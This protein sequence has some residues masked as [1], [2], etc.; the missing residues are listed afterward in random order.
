MAEPLPPLVLTAYRGEGGARGVEARLRQGQQA[1]PQQRVRA[2]RRVRAHA[3]DKSLLGARDAH[4]RRLARGKALK[5]GQLV[6][7][8]VQQ[9]AVLLRLRAVQHTRQ[10]VLPP[11]QHVRGS[12]RGETAAT[13]AAPGRTW[14]KPAYWR[15]TISERNSSRRATRASQAGVVWAYVS[16]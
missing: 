10:V 5:R 13:A 9:L 15:T 7:H 11:S 2:Q 6:E 8:V 12:V 14:A 4:A 16:Q 1:L 3:E